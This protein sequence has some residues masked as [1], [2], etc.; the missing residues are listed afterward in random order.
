MHQYPS[1]FK[2]YDKRTQEAITPTPLAP[3]LYPSPY[4]RHKTIK[5]HCNLQERK[6][7]LITELKFRIQVWRHARKTEP[8]R[9]DARSRASVSKHK[10]RCTTKQAIRPLILLRSS[11]RIQEWCWIHLSL[12]KWSFS[13]ARRKSWRCIISWYTRLQGE[14][15]S[16]FR[17]DDKSC[18]TVEAADT[19]RSCKLPW[20]YEVCCRNELHVYCSN[21][22]TPINNVPVVRW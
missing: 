1:H 3:S 18:K 11:M 8:R 22:I 14:K 6:R 20:R 17:G 9:G 15:K 5:A 19:C 13:L 2:F 10:L 12:Y 16:F 21:T 7:R 4:H